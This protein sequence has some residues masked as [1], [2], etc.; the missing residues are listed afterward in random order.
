M[1]PSTA[2]A[3]GMFSLLM[4]IGGYF[5]SPRLWPQVDGFPWVGFFLVAIFSVIALVFSIGDN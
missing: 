4:F 3:F 1:K 2:A 5:S